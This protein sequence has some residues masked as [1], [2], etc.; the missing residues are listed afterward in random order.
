[1]EKKISLSIPRTKPNFFDFNEFFPS[2]PCIGNFVYIRKLHL[3]LT[4]YIELRKVTTFLKFM[5]SL[6]LLSLHIDVNT[7]SMLSQPT[8]LPQVIRK[9]WVKVCPELNQPTSHM[10]DSIVMKESRSYRYASF[11]FLK[12]LKTI[13]LTLDIYNLSIGHHVLQPFKM[14]PPIIQK[15]KKLYDF[16]ISSFLMKAPNKVENLYLRGL[17]R[18]KCS[19]T[20]TLSRSF[21]NLKFLCLGEILDM[22]RDCLKHFQRLKIL[23]SYYKNNLDLPEDIESFMSCFNYFSTTKELDMG[24]EAFPNYEKYLNQ[25]SKVCTV[26][27][28]IKGKV[29]FNH[30]QDFINIKRYFPDIE[31][32]A[33]GR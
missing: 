18:M 30:P 6:E 28:S 9:S 3:K 22:D 7:D 11:N 15:H 13:Q 2:I 25:F 26:N 31:E 33:F 4:S 20:F 27:G 1:M 32:M 19:S 17:P 24:E 12:N 16:E 10:F 23:V 14:N 5:E 29:F 21:L 8:S